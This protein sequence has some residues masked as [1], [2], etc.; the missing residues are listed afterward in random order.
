MT[1]HRAQ[2]I[3]GAALAYAALALTNLPVCVLAA[4]LGPLYAWGLGGQPGECCA[5][6]WRAGSARRS[7][8]AFLLPAV[9][10]LYHANS[11]S[12]FNHS[13]TENLLFFSRPNGRLRS[14][15]AAPCSSPAWALL[16]CGMPPRGRW[17]W[18]RAP[19]LPRALAMLLFGA[20]ALTCVVSLPSG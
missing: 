20:L 6:W 10:L 5:A 4:H 3:A 7:P 13:W 14:F 9:G 8:A 15:G 1:G 17:A 12:L 11:A 16:C 19:G 2:G 18:L